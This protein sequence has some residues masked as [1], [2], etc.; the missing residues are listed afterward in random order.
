MGAYS[1]AEKTSSEA[2]GWP[3]GVIARDARSFQAARDGL[4]GWGA[5]RIDMYR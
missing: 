4:G 1:R 2:F 3:L 5:F